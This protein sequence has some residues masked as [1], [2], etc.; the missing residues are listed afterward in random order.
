MQ[1]DDFH[2]RER[3]RQHFHTAKESETIQQRCR[4][5]RQ[6][7]AARDTGTPESDTPG[8]SR[9]ILRSAQV[10]VG[11]VRLFWQGTQLC[12]TQCVGRRIAWRVGL[13]RY[14]GEMPV[15]RAGT[16]VAGHGAAYGRWQPF[17]RIADCDGPRQKCPG[18]IAEKRRAF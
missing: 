14:F 10:A 8:K 6:Y 18:K 12:A 13:R 9:G 15:D 3:L 16:A 4:T 17:G 7:A 2:E 11:H 5:Q 1:E